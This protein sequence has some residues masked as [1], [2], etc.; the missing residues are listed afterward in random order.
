MKMDGAAVLIPYMSF[1][2]S[3]LLTDEPGCKFVLRYDIQN[4]LPQFTKILSVKFKCKHTQT[5]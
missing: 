2:N 1:L 5:W 3:V 4:Y